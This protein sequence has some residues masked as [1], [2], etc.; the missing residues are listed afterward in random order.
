MNRLTLSNNNQLLIGMVLVLLII[1]TRGHHFATLQNL[2]GATW[3]CFFLAGVYLRPVWVL[4]GLFALAGLLDYAAITWGGV[5]AFCV[6][7]AYLLLLPAYGALWTAGRWYAGRHRFAWC[8]LL[9]LIGAALVGATVCELFSSGGFYFFSGRFAEPTLTE[10]GVRLLRYF[11]AYLQ[12]LAFYLGVAAVV[13]LLFGLVR[14]APSS[15]HLDA[16]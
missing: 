4:P 1:A 7:P 3:A 13:H 12:S 8:T 6:T 11:P 9:P 14:G 15:H 10:F 2:P 16:G 5:N